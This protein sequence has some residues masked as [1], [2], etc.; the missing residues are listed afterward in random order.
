[1]LFIR[2]SAS[3]RSKRLSRRNWRKEVQERRR[4]EEERDAQLDLA[5]SRVRDKRAQRSFARV[6]NDDDGDDD[7]ARVLTMTTFAQDL[8]GLVRPPG[9][10]IVSTQTLKVMDESGSMRPARNITEWMQQFLIEQ[11][12]FREEMR[13]LGIPRDVEIGQPC[14]IFED[15]FNEPWCFLI[16][17]PTCKSMMTA[18]WLTSVDTAQEEE[19]EV[20]KSLQLAS[21]SARAARI[22]IDRLDPT[23]TIWNLVE[24]FVTRNMWKDCLSNFPCKL[25]QIDQIGE[26]MMK[27]PRRGDTTDLIKAFLVSDD[28]E[29][30][31]YFECDYSSTVTMTGMSTVVGSFLLST[32]QD[33]TAE[34]LTPWPNRWQT[35]TGWR[36][37]AKAGPRRRYIDSDGRLRFANDDNELFWNNNNAAG[38]NDE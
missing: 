3:E 11:F 30:H 19:K 36:V 34:S 25:D 38:S 20:I 33:I 22:V 16:E 15:D 12:V 21:M 13:K 17:S 14:A 7:A 27:A 26:Y 18:Y 23:N 9:T 35:P 32:S 8:D 31:A 4:L 24:P 29:D 37:V 28:G 5:L 2:R 1:M 10:V 6:E